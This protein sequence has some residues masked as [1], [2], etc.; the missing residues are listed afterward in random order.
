MIPDP[1]LELHLSLQVHML[2]IVLLYCTKKTRCYSRSPPDN[3][4]GRCRLAAAVCSRSS[5]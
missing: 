3:G 5:L 4:G 1:A 2:S